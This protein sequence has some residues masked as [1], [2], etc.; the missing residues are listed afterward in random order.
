MYSVMLNIEK[1]RAVVV[2]GGTVAY[3]KI[4]GLLAEGAIILVIS[5]DVTKEIETLIEQKRVQWTARK[6]EATDV[7]GAFLVIAATNCRNVNAQIASCCQSY[8]LVNIVDDPARSTFHV[9]AKVQR[10]ELVITV[11]TGGASPLLAKKIRDD[12]AVQYPEDYAD[13]IE[14]LSR[15]RKQILTRSLA[16]KQRKELIRQ[17]QQDEYYHSLEARHI[18]LQQLNRE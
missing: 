6:F 10:G 13:Y 8:Q 18:F 2:G 5:P 14:F 3:R 15:A 1:K 9:P 12:I 7:F 11:S 4:I 16:P 17:S